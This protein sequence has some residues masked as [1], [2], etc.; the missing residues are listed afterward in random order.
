MGV[1]QRHLADREQPRQDRDDRRRRVRMARDRARL[2]EAAGSAANRRERRRSRIRDSPAR[3]RAWNHARS[4]RGRHRFR[5]IDRESVNRTVHRYA[6]SPFVGFAAVVAIA[7]NGGAV[8]GA[9][10]LDATYLGGSAADKV[11]AVASDAA[12]NTYV[13][14]LTQS[15]DFPTANALQLANAGATD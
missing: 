3:H 5:A 13:A 4:A 15:L 12:G 11:L 8:H 1:A 7:S 10:T 14:G 6:R 2:A 9:T